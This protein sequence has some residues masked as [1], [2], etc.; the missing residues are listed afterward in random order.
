MSGEGKKLVCLCVCCREEGGGGHMTE[1]SEPSAAEIHKL[2]VANWLVSTTAELGHFRTT[3]QIW[4][5]L[6]W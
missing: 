1:R 5:R 6:L 4:A 2:R 3:Q